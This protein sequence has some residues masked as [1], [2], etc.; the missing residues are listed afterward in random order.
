MEIK[1]LLHIILI[2][3]A[4]I[5]IVLSLAS[6]FVSLF[7]SKLIKKMTGYASGY[8]NITIGTQVIVNLTV[9]TLNWSSGTITGGNTN[10]TLTTHGN[11]SGT[12]L[13]GNWSGNDAKAF[14]VENIGSVNSSLFLYSEKNASTFFASLTNS[15]QEFKFNVSNKDSNSCSG[16]SLIGNWIDVNT[17]SPGTKYCSQFSYSR[18]SNE[19]YIDVSLT[20]PYDSGNIGVISDTITITVDAAS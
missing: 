16:T 12:V 5:V 2:I 10:S 7:D 20:V 14:V 3:I 19:I 18:N 1:E 9:D 4:I 17:T 8:V 11:N 13:R 15:N 6:I